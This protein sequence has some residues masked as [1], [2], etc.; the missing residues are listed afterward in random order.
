M[1]SMFSYGFPRVF[2]HF[3]MISYGFRSGFLYVH[4]RDPHA[5]GY[6]GF[7]TQVLP[8]G[9][10]RRVVQARADTLWGLINKR[11]LK[12]VNY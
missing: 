2:P 1:K 6:G 8:F 9:S 10:A 7:S 12:K 4:P 3:P 5:S 11:K